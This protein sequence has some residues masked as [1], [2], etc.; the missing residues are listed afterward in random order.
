MPLTLKAHIP[1]IEETEDTFEEEEKRPLEFWE[2]KQRELLTN[3][4]DYS[5]KSLAELVDRGGIDLKPKYQRRHRWDAA[6]QSKLIESFLM[7]VP[8][9]P[10]YLNEDEFGKY[11]V[12]DGKQRLTAIAEFMGGRLKLKDLEVFSDINDMTFHALPM[13]FRNAIETR[14]NLRAVII[15]KQ[16][17]SDVKLEVFKR[18]NTGGVK[19]NAQELRNAAYTGRLNDLILDLSESREFHGLLQ[20]KDKNS[21][22]LYQEMRD[23]ELVLRFLT[24]KE[25]W[26][27]FSGGIKS[28][29]DTF[30]D[31][32]RHME[33]EK[34]TAL[35]NDFQNTLRTVSAAFG[36]NAFRRWVP[37][38]GV[39]RK[40][41][42]VSLYDAQMFA[43]YGIA[44]ERVK[45]HQPK[46]ID[47]V[48][49]LFSSPDFRKNVDTATNTPSFFKDRVKIMKA[50]IEDVINQ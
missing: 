3:Q 46:L 14:P 1:D 24:F 36:D 47:G 44:P 27:V 49:R 16:S 37:E 20:I 9:P 42:L 18:L 40:Q 13:L 35:K 22:R 45:G 5:L 50:M 6:R 26:S 48:K 38:R 23:A 19:L 10:V 31:K 28:S 8:V 21:S 29:M 43:C 32:N 4:V 39:W 15:L 30:S 34:I 11:S 33:I 2:R 25:N 12:I 41:V 17:D 7:N